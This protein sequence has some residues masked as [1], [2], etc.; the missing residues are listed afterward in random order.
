MV[1]DLHEQ[2]GDRARSADRAVPVAGTSFW[3]K[4]VHASTS[5]SASG[6]SEVGMGAAIR[7]RN[8]SVLAG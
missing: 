5:S 1:S 7:S 4:P 6:S 3:L 8:N 2:R